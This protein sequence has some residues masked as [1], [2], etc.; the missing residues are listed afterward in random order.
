MQFFLTE[1][2]QLA[3][4]G[5]GLVIAVFSTWEIGICLAGVLMEEYDTL[6]VTGQGP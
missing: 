4:R 2:F 1:L 6:C 3:G 5:V